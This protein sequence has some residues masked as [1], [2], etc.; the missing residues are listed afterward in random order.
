MPRRIGFCRQIATTT[1]DGR[2]DPTLLGWYA[3]P[4]L[5]EPAKDS[6]YAALPDHRAPMPVTEP[7]TTS[8]ICEQALDLVE[9]CRRDCLIVTDHLA[10]PRRV[11]FVVA[12]ARLGNQ[13]EEVLDDFRVVGVR[14]REYARGRVLLNLGPCRLSLWPSFS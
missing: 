7:L 11:V 4:E 10:N 13:L 8:A 9:G 14:P 5:S 1:H 2:P 3:V 12:P 6:S